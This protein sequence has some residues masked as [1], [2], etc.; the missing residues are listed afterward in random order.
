MTHKANTCPFCKEGTMQPIHAD[1]T[2]FFISC[3]D[4][5]TKPVTLIPNSGFP[6]KILGCTNCGNLI[7]NNPSIHSC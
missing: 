6:V 7:L 1:G 3:I 5:S 4:E 2:S